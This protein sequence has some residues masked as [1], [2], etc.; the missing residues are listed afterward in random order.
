MSFKAIRGA[1]PGWSSLDRTRVR[2]GTSVSS[3]TLADLAAAASRVEGPTPSLL[4][5]VR[6]LIIFSDVGLKVIV[7]VYFRLIFLWRFFHGLSVR[8]VLS[9]Q[10]PNGT[11]L[12]FSLCG[13]GEE[14]IALES[15]INA[16]RLFTCRA[17]YGTEVGAVR[18]TLET[19][20]GMFSSPHFYWL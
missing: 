13:A 10:S 5:A 16:N 3:T 15:F 12:E 14:A 18:L 9:H 19:A 17:S 1:R 2:H 4:E 6:C 7:L 8:P 11:A 20:T